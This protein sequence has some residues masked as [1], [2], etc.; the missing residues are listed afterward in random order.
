MNTVAEPVYQFRPED[1]PTLA[2]G[3]FAPPHPPLRRLGYGAVGLL[4]GIAATF[5][6]ALVNVDVASLAGSLG[7]FVAEASLLPAI[8]IAMNASTNLLLIKARIQLGIPRTTQALLILYIAAG[9]A[10]FVFTGLA[11]A[12][13]VRAASGMAGA[14]LITLSVFYLLQVFPPKARPVALVIGVGLAQLGTPLARLVP[15]EMLALGSWQGLHLI[16]IGVAAAVL[17]ASLALPLPPSERSRALEPLDFLSAGLVASAITLVCAVLGQGR[18]LWW[19]DTPWLGGALV[20]AVALFA[21]AVLIELH[22]ARPLLQ[23]EW[24]TSLD[25]LRFAAVAL[26]VRLALAEQTYGSVGLLSS[27]GL[28]NDQLRT[29]FAIV[30]VAIVLGIV[31]AV[32]TLSVERLPYQVMVAALLIAWGA[33]LDSGATNIT[34]PEQLYF[35]QALLGFGTTLFIG[36]AL[37]YGFLRVLSRGPDVVV[38]LLVLFSVTQNVGG[39]LGSALLG[40]YQIA[41]THAHTAALSEHLLGADPQVA[42]RLQA[43]GPAALAHAMTREANVL[44]FNDVFTLVAALAAATALFI[45]CGLA[46]NALRRVLK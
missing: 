23:I 45:A 8:Y 2:G 30:A 33:W 29:L 19:H 38:S 46:T 37:V 26:V 42:A 43:E 44:A 16:E 14:A 4:A 7:V 12:V 32:A 36:P 13:A 40:S 34:R 25:I 3:P 35:S 5:G 15:V 1:R 17:A 39:L 41:S 24:I 10:Q 21:V 9:L 11:A 20:A 27:S 18:F 22:R 6:N 31:A 28:I